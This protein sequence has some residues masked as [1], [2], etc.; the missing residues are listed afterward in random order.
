MK[1]STPALLASCALA[2]CSPLAAWTD[3]APKLRDI[4]GIV[5]SLVVTATPAAP[6][7]GEQS[8]VRLKDG[9]LFLLWSEFLREDLLPA[10]ERPPPSPLRRDPTGDDGYARISG[11]TSAD[12]GKSWSAPFVVVDDKDALV[13]C[14]SPSLTRMADGRILLAYSWRSGGNGAE[15]YGNCAKMVRISADEGKTWSERTRITPDNAEYH[16]GC[17]DRAWTLDN[18]RVVVQCHTIFPPSMAQPG[19]GYRR[20]TMGT[21]YAYSDD[22]G[23]T[24]KRTGVFKDPIAGNAGRFEEACLAQRADGS[25]IQFIRNWRGQSF[26]AESTDRGSTW[27]TPRPSG[28]FSALAPTY[29]TRLPKS[30]DLL[31]IWNPTWNPDARI[32]GQRTVLACA[33]SKDGGKTWGLPKALET[34]PDQW[35]EYPGVTFDG[36][37]ALVYYR[38]FASDR[39]RCDL[40]QARVPL[41]W[42]YDDT[43]I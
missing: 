36:D 11:K 8:V 32:Y 17:H 34:N 26:V 42:F 20:T 41:S 24:W 9:R 5:K 23:K 1:A 43:Q 38:V 4:P 3:N 28:V 21:Y 15:N 22:H 40:V 2:L 7:H 39:K 33:V 25:L 18:G 6:K 19:P 37:H 31:M 29:I 27:S 35:A 10:G 12:G 14:I 13:N 16:T 30:G